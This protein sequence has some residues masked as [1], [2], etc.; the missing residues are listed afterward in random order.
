MTTESLADATMHDV[1]PGVALTDL[2]A[3]EDDGKDVEM[4]PDLANASLETLSDLSNPHVMLTYYRRLLPYKQLYL[5]LNHAQV[6]SKQFTNREFAMTLKDDVYLR[7]NSYADAEEFKKDILRLNPTRF[8]IGP[9]YSARPKDRKQLMKATFKPVLRELVFDIDMTD[10]DDIRTCCSDKGMCKRCWQFIAMAVKILD[11]SLRDDFAFQHLLW[12]YSGRR[13]IHLWISDPEALAL[14][15]EQRKALVAYIEVVKGGA[16]MDRKVNLH[17]PLHPGITR[18]LN[19][20][21]PY[22]QSV[23]LGDQDCF[24]KQEQWE[25]VQRIMTVKGESTWADKEATRDLQA[26]EAK[27]GQTLSAARWKAFLS[28]PGQKDAVVQDIILQY[29]YPRIDTEV[30]KKQNHLLKSPFC[31]H[32]GTGRVC[33]PLQTADVDGFDPESVP[34]VGELL[35]ELENLARDGDDKAGWDKTRLRP[36]VEAFERHISPLMKAEVRKRKADKEESLEF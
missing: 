13:G 9:V 27:S 32:P 22:F 16:K 8:E 18:S 21:K 19:M 26:V 34:T 2:F 28:V 33:V 5:W 17:R 25:M 23:V 7:Y 20:L 12:V 3:D 36:Y 4:K 1:K 24:A 29:T 15:D 31:I 6:P 10:Y 35:L 30:S 14:T 11:T